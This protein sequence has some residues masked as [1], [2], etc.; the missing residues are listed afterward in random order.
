MDNQYYNEYEPQTQG[1]IVSGLIGALVG[2]LI[3]AAVWAFAALVLNIISAL[4]GFLIGFLA[5]KGY[6]LLKGRPGKAKLFCVI[7]AIIIGVVVGTGITYGWLFHQEYLD[8]IAGWTDARIAGF[9]ELDYWVKL[10]TMN[11]GDILSNLGQGLLF[12]ALGCIGLFR[13]LLAKPTATPSAP[14][15]NAEA[16]AV[17]LDAA[18]VPPSTSENQNL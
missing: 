3:G 10:F 5:A 16:A 15:A 12:A 7:I 6:D 8:K 11:Q 2:A 13:D 14:A 18:A 17:N 4:I 1:S 9:P